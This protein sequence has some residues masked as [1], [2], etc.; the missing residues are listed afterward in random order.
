MTGSP[1]DETLP[2]MMTNQLAAL[3]SRSLA[4]PALVAGVDE[5]EWISI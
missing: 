4:V 3:P 5:V 1:H 2:Q